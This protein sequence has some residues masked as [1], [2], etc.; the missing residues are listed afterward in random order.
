LQSILQDNAKCGFR[1]F[2]LGHSCCPPAGV[3][4]A[5]TGGE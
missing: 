1:W 2:L 4:D 3:L 5:H